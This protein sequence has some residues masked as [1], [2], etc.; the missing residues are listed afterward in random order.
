MREE[1]CI[2]NDEGMV[3]DG[4]SSPQEAEDAIRERYHPDDDLRVEI[5]EDEE[6]DEED[7]EEEDGE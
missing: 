4:F 5:V 2:V 3:E 7:D 1:W 6:D